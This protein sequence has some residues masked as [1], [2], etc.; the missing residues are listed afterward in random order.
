MFN[1]HIM[2]KKMTY[3]AILQC[4]QMFPICYGFL[5]I[6]V[7]KISM[8]FTIQHEFHASEF[9]VVVHRPFSTTVQ[10]AYEEIIA[11]NAHLTYVFH[12]RH[13]LIGTPDITVID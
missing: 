13:P 5:P 2:L 7:Y 10:Q 4:S 12:I 6:I 11:Q 9:T 3:Y 1:G 8:N